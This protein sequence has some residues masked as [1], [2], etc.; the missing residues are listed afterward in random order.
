MCSERVCLTPAATG[1]IGKE[2]VHETP[3]NFSKGIAVKE[4]KRRGTMTVAEEIER[5]EKSQLL[6]AGF[7]P[8]A[9]D[10]FVSFLIMAVLSASSFAR[11]AVEADD[12][13]P[14][15]VLDKSGSGL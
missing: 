5:F 11:C 3:G 4:K 13:L 2:N 9:A 10:F 1:Q 12:R 7:F 8:F 15:P 6:R 14:V